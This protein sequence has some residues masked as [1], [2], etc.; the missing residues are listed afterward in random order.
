V[1]VIALFG[2]FAGFKIAAKFTRRLEQAGQ[3]PYI[4]AMR[5]NPGPD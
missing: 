3:A 1:T 2:L 5:V 4:R